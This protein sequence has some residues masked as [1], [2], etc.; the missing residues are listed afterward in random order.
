MRCSEGGAHETSA[1]LGQTRA[2]GSSVP[3]A[4]AALSLRPLLM[5]AG[6]G[7]RQ[8]ALQAARIH[9]VAHGAA[10]SGRREPHVHATTTAVWGS[11]STLGG[12]RHINVP[13][14]A[15]CPCAAA[16][17]NQPSLAPGCPP[18]LCYS[19]ATRRLDSSPPGR[20]AWRGGLSET[21]RHGCCGLGRCAARALVSPAAAHAHSLSSILSPVRPSSHFFTTWQATRSATM[22]GHSKLA[23]RYQSQAGSASFRRVTFLAAH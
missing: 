6:Q 22:A 8:A 5:S 14:G 17:M 16:C 13:P 15:T 11:W 12:P 19:T 23:T 7:L 3:V 18:G 9:R 20:A 4:V 2:Q 1:E 21:G 10:N